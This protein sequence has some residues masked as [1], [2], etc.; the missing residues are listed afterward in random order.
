M[1]EAHVI[2]KSHTEVPDMDCYLWHSAE[3]ALTLARHNAGE[4]WPTCHL[5]ITVG[6]ILTVGERVI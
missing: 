2:T 6:Q 1:S 4:S 5:G 3:M